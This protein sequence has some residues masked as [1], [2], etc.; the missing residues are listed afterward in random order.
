ML[1]LLC[2]PANDLVI[3]PGKHFRRDPLTEPGHHT[4]IKGTFV[5]V[6]MQTEE[7]LQVRVHGNLFGDILIRQGFVSRFD[8]ERSQ[9]HP[10]VDRSLAFLASEVIGI[11]QIELPPGYQLA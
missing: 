3:H 8:Q 2:F 4:G 1:V 9:R 6:F 10:G 7:V 5:P 11:L